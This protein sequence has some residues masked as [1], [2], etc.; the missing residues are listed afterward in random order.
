[1]ERFFLDYLHYAIIGGVIIYIVYKQMNVYNSTTK[2]ILTFQNI[3]PKFSYFEIEK[4]K[5]DEA[6][7]GIKST[8]EN[9]ILESITVSISRY[10][11]NNRGAVS[12]FHIIKDIV[13]RN[14][15]SVEE[16]IT[17]QIPMPLYYGLMGTMFGILVGVGYFVFSGAL[18]AMFETGKSFDPNLQ[19]MVEAVKPGGGKIEGKDGISALLGGVA[20]AMISSIIGIFLTTRGS[21]LLKNSK[22]ELEKTKNN[23]LSWIQAELLPELTTDTTVALEKMTRNLLSFNQTFSDNTIKLRETLSLVNESYKTQAEIL[24]AVNRLK[25]ND[26]ATANIKVY[27]KLKEST[28]EIG[29]FATYLNNVNGYIS[30]INTLNNKLDE[31]ESRTKAIE[32][33]GFFFREERANMEKWNGVV[34]QSMAK[35]DKELS[36][37]VE[38]L[39]RSIL[40][41][42]DELSK[43][44]ILQRE[45]FTSLVD[46]QQDVLQQAIE[47]QQATVCKAAEES[48]DIIKK[49]FEEQ[50]KTLHNRTTEIEIIVDE[51][52]NLSTL[53]VTLDNQGKTSVAQNQKID[54]LVNAISEL[55]QLRTTGTDGISHSQIPKNSRWEK[56]LSIIT[57]SFLIALNLVYIFLIMR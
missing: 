2:K 20:L 42:F 48:Q 29:Q 40:A 13:D 23:F 9:T 57:I 12:D 39:K 46:E 55:V 7:L 38:E 35:V 14:C 33:M 30:S 45:G 19:T 18:D 53:K 6:I 26:I 52:K 51:L 32:D 10:L 49:L 24:E 44:T 36:S 1:M 28:Q 21:S 25:I 27:D 54:K 17:T 8:H 47:K 11:Y 4:R 16:E 50:K 22:V 34:S 43:H 41:Q 37:S 15:D 3:F 5:E 31:H 56:T